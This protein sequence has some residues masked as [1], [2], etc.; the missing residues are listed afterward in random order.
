MIQMKRLTSPNTAKTKLSRQPTKHIR[1]TVLSHAKPYIDMCFATLATV[2][3]TLTVEHLVHNM[4]HVTPNDIYKKVSDSVVT[5][6]SSVIHTDPFSPK[7]VTESKLGTGTGFYYKNDGYVVTNAHVVD[8]AFSVQINDNDAVVVGTDSAH[9]IAILKTEESI[10]NPRPIIKC[11]Q[12]PFIGQS[13]L[14]IGNPYGFDRSMSEGIIS[15]TSR[16][17]DSEDHTLFN[18]LQ[19]DAAI[20]PGNSGGPLLNADNGCLL[21]V[22]TAIISQSGSSSGV[23]FAV[24][25]AVVDEVANQIINHQVKD[26]LQLG[27]TLLPDK[28]SN[29]LGVDGIIIAD[30]IPGSISDHLGL[31]GTQ[32]DDYGRPMI[33]DIIIGIN[34]KKISKN[35]DLVSVLDKLR[36]GDIVELNVI[37]SS[38]IEN[39]KIQF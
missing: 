35:S 23:G 9:D 4:T 5:I 28:Y 14:A 27:V 7:S 30:I 22:N 13:V 24:P 16:I 21:G 12:E 6:T 20:N 32:R 1:N 11:R 38:G 18:L 17:L 8:G 37:R 25:I 34:G 29:I 31:Q 15:G 36:K 19:I 3:A 2:T 10:T 39:F 33:G 26:K